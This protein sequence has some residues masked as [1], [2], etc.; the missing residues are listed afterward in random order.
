MRF[1]L[2]TVHRF[3]VGLGVVGVLALGGCGTTNDP[4]N[5]SGTQTAYP[6]PVTSGTVN[7][8]N[9]YSGYGV[10]QSIDLVQQ[11]NAGNTGIAGSGIGLGTLAGAVIG[12]VLGNQVGGGTGK[13][14]AT[15]AGVAGGAYVGH[16]IDNRQQNQTV[17]VYRFNVR[18]ENGAH[19]T[20]TQNTAAGFRVGDRV[21]ID[22]GAM[23][24]Y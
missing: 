20:F 2:K 9:V 24:R 16:E 17:N 10:V 12:G 21:R 23:Q 1:A 13:T 6:G 19:Q 18:M 7:P 22:N 3:G 11:G 14:V 8:G 4:F 15:V 5:T